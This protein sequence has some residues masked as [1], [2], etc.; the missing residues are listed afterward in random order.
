MTALHE[1]ATRTLVARSYLRVSEDRGGLKRS[2]TEQDTENTRAIS[3]QGWVQGEPYRDDGISASRYSGKIRDDFQRLIQDLQAHEFG[4]DVLVLWETSRG[5]REMWEWVRL[6]DL[7]AEVGVLVHITTHGRTYDPRNWRDRRSLLEDGVDNE[8][9]SAKVSMRTTRTAAAEAAAGRPTGKCPFGYKR[10][11]D[12]STGKMVTQVPD[13]E[14]APMVRDL[15]ERI[16]KGHAMKAIAR[17]FEEQGYRNGKGEPFSAAHLRSLARQH[18]YTGLRVH[19]PGRKAGQDWRHLIRAEHLIEANWEPIVERDLF[20]QVQEI[21]EDPRRKTARPGRANHLLSHVAVCGACGAWMVWR[22]HIPGKGRDRV[23]LYQCRNGHARVFEEDLDRFGERALLDYLEGAALADDLA[24]QE[25]DG[26][27]L[28]QA[29]ADAAA[30]RAQL[31]GLADA[32][33][34]GVSPQTVAAAEQKIK[35]AL[36]AAETRERD[37]STPAALRGLI[38]PGP[39]VRARWESTPLAAKRAIARLVFSE[40]RLGLLRVMP[41]ESRGPFRVPVGDRVRLGTEEA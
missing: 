30:L 28:R 16:A 6:I 36:A 31:K 12:P 25:A 7:L 37:L 9:E 21:L 17:D 4:A 40:D 38:E 3:A 29:R 24:A 18:A 35:R 10:V 15:Y 41:T 1:A 34:E 5:S 23:A 27:A 2:T 13:P 20:W 26:A 22:N 32:L 11:Y 19:I 33:A 8:A 14:T 39:G